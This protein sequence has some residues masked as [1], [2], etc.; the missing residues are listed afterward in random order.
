M[1]H[2]LRIHHIAAQPPSSRATIKIER[3]TREI[4]WTD[5]LHV[6][7][8]RHLMVIKG[9]RERMQVK[10]STRFSLC[11]EVWS[12]TMGRMGQL[13]GKDDVRFRRKRTSNFMCYKSVVQRSTQKQRRWK[14]VYTLLCR[15]N[16]RVLPPVGGNGAIPGGAHDI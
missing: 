3:N 1:A 11:E 8:Q 12:R 4:Y 15:T 6:D 2:F 14:I 13:G 5:H 16:H 10:C 9:Q 7:V